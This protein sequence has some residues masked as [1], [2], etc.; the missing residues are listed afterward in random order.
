MLVI[1]VESGDYEVDEDAVTACTG[2]GN[3]GPAPLPTA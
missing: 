2:C 1:D 3:G